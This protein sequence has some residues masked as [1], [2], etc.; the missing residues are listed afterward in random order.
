MKEKDFKEILTHYLKGRSTGSQ[1]DHLS[2][3]EHYLLRENS[4]SVFQSKRHKKQLQKD[5]LKRIKK[6]IYPKRSNWINMAAAILIVVALGLTYYL[7]TPLNPPMEYVEISTHEN[8]IKSI[9][10]SDSTHVVLNQNSLLRFPKSFT[11]ASRNV[12]LDGEAYF[13]VSFDRKRPFNVF[14]DSVVTKV[15]GTEFNISTR[16]K[17]TS[18]ALIK[19]S[20]V[21][22][23][24]GKSKLLKP[25]Q[26]ISIDYKTAQVEQQTFDP[27]LEIFWMDQQLSFDNVELGSIVKI[28]ESKFG[29]TISISDSSLSQ[30]SI[31]GT[32]KGK[33]ITS[34]LLSISKAADF[35]F[36]IN[37]Q[38]QIIIYKS[39]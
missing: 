7:S 33:G 14:A 36:K 20:V 13:K 8:Q 18:V 22:T 16:D 3:F 21:V 15:L 6:E 38:E 34:I 27:Q 29:K 30:I 26:K 11:D 23:G 37:D 2:D 39:D 32:F 19:G 28:L 35:S 4:K 5:L 25:K 10:L 17:R 1:R 9:L 12:L 24:L 31:T